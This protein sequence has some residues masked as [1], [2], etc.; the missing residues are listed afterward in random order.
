MPTRRS[1]LLTALVCLAALSAFGETV[2]LK[3]G[4]LIKGKVTGSNAKYFWIKTGQ[5]SVTK[6]SRNSVY[7]IYGDGAKVEPVPPPVNPRLRSAKNWPIPYPTITV[8]REQK[9]TA[10]EDRIVKAGTGDER[11]KL[12]NAAPKA[13]RELLPSLETIERWLA[14]PRKYPKA[15]GRAVKIDLPWKGKNPRA[16]AIVGV[17]RG[18][19][20]TKRAWPVVI[21]LHGTDDTPDA[22]VS[23]MKGVL[24]KDCFLIGPRT[25]NKVHFW[26][27]TEEWQNVRRIVGHLADHYRIDPR[28]IVCCGGSGGG[29]GTWGLTTLHPEVFCAGA[30]SA[31]MPP[32]GQSAVTR[33]KHVP[34]FIM[35]GKND[36]IPV[37][38]PRRMHAAMTKAGVPHIYLEHDGGHYP[39][40]AQSKRMREFVQQAPPKGNL[41]PRPALLRFIQEARAA[42]PLAAPKVYGGVKMKSKDGS[43][44]WT[45][46]R[47]SPPSRR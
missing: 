46:A 6:V 36:H 2:Q 34:F 44:T 20:P 37:A 42:R 21:A 14:A 16:I 13:D 7:R 5:W 26:Y 18:Y 15:A 29:M 25:T 10:L 24:R 39:N 23:H 27:N 3:N 9:V 30:S 22:I 47:G 33:L 12:Y 41:S 1:S 4:K 8:A 43:F 11:A 28:R 19:D 40:A 38:G 35:H 31:G 45:P 17:P 32:I